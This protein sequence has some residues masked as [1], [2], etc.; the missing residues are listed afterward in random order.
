M[1]LLRSGIISETSRQK[2]ILLSNQYT[3]ENEE[4]ELWNRFH[5][6]WVPMEGIGQ[7]ERVKKGKYDGCNLY[8]CMK[9]DQW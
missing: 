6:G 1:Y 4:Q 2:E 3:L 9:V 5:L 8:S 7:T